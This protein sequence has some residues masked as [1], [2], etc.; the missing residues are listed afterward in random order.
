MRIEA[1]LTDPALGTMLGGLEDRT[2][3]EQDLE[4]TGEDG[5]KIAIPRYASLD[6]TVTITDSSGKEV[7]GG[8]MP[9]G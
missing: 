1:I 2:R 9:F 3:K 6:P 5:K 8:K 4:I 7:A